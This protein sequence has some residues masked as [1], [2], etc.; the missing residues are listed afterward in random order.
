MEMVE[1]NAIFFGKKN[2]SIDKRK[3]FKEN[4]RIWSYWLNLE[5]MTLNKSKSKK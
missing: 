5:I 1:N 2:H 3:Y 4:Q